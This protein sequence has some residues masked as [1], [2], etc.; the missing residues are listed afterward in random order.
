VVR[1][2]SL[3]ESRER[4]WRTGHPRQERRNVSSN[5]PDSRYCHFDN[6]VIDCRF[7]DE[8]HQAAIYASRS[9]TVKLSFE[10][11]ETGLTFDCYV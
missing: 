5:G 9:G 10:R 8:I 2:I 1:S 4:I 6:P 3:G 7:E 11:E